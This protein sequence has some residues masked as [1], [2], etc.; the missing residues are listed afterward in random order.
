[1]TKVFGLEVEWYDPHAMLTRSFVMRLYADERQVEMYD[2]RSRRT[3]LKKSPLPPSIMTSELYVGNEIVLH[4]RV[5]KIVRYADRVTEEL[6]SQAQVGSTCVLT[7]AC[8]VGGKLGAA[9]SVL[10]EANL[11]IKKL[12]MVEL[13]ETEAR[14]CSSML[15]QGDTMAQLLG[16]GKCVVV[17]VVQPD[18]VEALKTACHQISK[19]LGA[20]L[21]PAAPD[22]LAAKELD[23]FA[24]GGS[25]PLSLWPTAQYGPNSTCCIVRPHAMACNQLGTILSHIEAACAY[26]I[27]ALGIFRLDI[28]AATEFLEIYDGVVPEFEAS[29]KQLSSGPCC[30]LELKAQDAVNKFRETAGPWDV[31]FAR[32]IRPTSIRAKFGIDGVKN[33]I[34]CTDLPDDG[35]SEL[36]YFFDVLKPC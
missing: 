4:S 20:D 9:L 32:E 25:R 19:V 15:H 14:E 31:N 8:I 22:K 18:A 6:L 3:F 27:S 28:P 13:S 7:P 30:A 26:E 23:G 36:R 1:M 21:A 12:K 33:A 10:E 5:L 16:S 17:S 11:T 24:F 34:H 29:V 2:A 35:E